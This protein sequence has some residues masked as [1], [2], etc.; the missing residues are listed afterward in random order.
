M[1]WLMVWLVLCRRAQ[2]CGWR[3]V[4][5]CP[6]ARAPPRVPHVQELLWCALAYTVS[7]TDLVPRGLLTLCPGAC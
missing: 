3:C 4:S 1:L 5:E 6:R 7:P 2:W